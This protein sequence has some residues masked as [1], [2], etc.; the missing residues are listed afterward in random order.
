M[1][2]T[3]QCRLITPDERMLDENVTYAQLPLWDGQAGVLPGR[4]P[5]LAKLG[6]G[7]LRLDFPQGGSRSYFVEAGF[8]QMV[9]NRLTVLAE[10]A[11]AVESLSEQEIQAELAEAQAR[12]PRTVEEA[13]QVALD[14]R[15]AQAKLRLVQAFK[16][17]G[18]GI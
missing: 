2:R 3:F 5:M 7:E 6:L 18:A 4:A 8:V 16:A 9:D 13:Q 1:A 15:R 11:Q 10:Q 14:R 12:T 17:R